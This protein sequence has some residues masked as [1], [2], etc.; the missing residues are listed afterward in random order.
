M[1]MT[2]VSEKC[3]LDAFDGLFAPLERPFPRYSEPLSIMPGIFFYYGIGL[4]SL[5]ERE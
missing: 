4:K 1:T 5:E 3:P 2:K